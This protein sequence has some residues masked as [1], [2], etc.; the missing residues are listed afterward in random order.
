MNRPLRVLVVD[1]DAPTRRLLAAALMSERVY[2]VTTARDGA[3]A[4]A[5]FCREPSFDLVLTD[6]RMPE[7]PGTELIKRI[8]ALDK[9]V[10]ILVFTA[11]Q[12]DQGVARALES[13]ADDY[14]LKPV[15]LRELRRTTAFLCARRRQALEEAEKAE[16]EAETGGETAQEEIPLF[17]THSDGSFVELTV[18][19]VSEQI[20]RVQRFADQLVASGL[21]DK[22]RRELR[23]ALEEVLQNA[24]E[25]GNRGDPQKT[26]RFAYRILP[27]RV[28]FRIEDEG[29]GFDPY[30]SAV[31]VE[32]QAALQK[33]REK[34]GKR[35]G[36]W[37]LFLA[38]HAV[39]EITFNR[40]GNVVF[41]TKYFHP[42]GLTAMLEHTAPGDRENSEAFSVKRHRR[43]S[44]LRKTTRLLRK[45]D[46]R[47]KKDCPEQPPA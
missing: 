7:M 41:L 16:R 5:L 13:G 20:P 23:L 3:E 19:S 45:H 38:R 31:P 33:E 27:D 43:T 22:S 42:G 15:D 6:L 21:D 36:G 47:E 34:A 18:E 10:P 32:D 39:D 40:K 24:V 11:V 17:R 30:Y 2:E 12:S 37:G 44:M 25:W 8:R 26:V 28:T 14:L 29:E 35:I 1:D 4:L 46:P 9:R